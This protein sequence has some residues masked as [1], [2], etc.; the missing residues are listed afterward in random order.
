MTVES[1][2]AERALVPAGL[3]AIVC[4]SFQ[5]QQV[6]L[7]LFLKLKKGTG[8]VLAQGGQILRTGFFF[9]LH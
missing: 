6:R 2:Q 8:L 3:L 9:R 4:R 1:L 5:L 7:V